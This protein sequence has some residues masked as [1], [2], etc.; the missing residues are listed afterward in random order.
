MLVVH[1]II[2]GIP[3]FI[4][5][6]LKSFLYAHLAK[7]SARRGGQLFANIFRLPFNLVLK[8]STEPTPN[9]AHGLRIA[10]SI[11]GVQ[12]PLLIDYASTDTCSYTLM[13]WIEGDCCS[14]VWDDLTP[15][16][17]QRIVRE[18]RMQI[19]VLRSRTVGRSRCICA[20][21]GA[22][23]SDPHIPWVR[24]DPQVFSSSSDFFKQVWVGLNFD[25]LRNTIKPAIQP[26]IDR[27]AV[28]IVF[29]HGDLLPKNLIL[30]GGLSQRRRSNTALTIIDWEYSGWMPLPWEALKATWLVCD[31]DEEE[32]YG[33]MREVFP[34][35]LADLEADWLWRTKANIPI[36][37]PA[38]ATRLVWGNVACIGD[39]YA[40]YDTTRV[41]RDLFNQSVFKRVHVQGSMRDTFAFRRTMKS[42]E[43][44]STVEELSF[45]YDEA[46]KSVDFEEELLE[47]HLKHAPRLKSLRINFSEDGN[48]RSYPNEFQ[49]ALLRTLATSAPG[50][51]RTLALIN[52][53]AH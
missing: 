16:D 44:I 25:R 27:D 31:R 13:S 14:D 9:E 18:L 12:A 35:S 33:M 30:P 34:E 48:A 49:Y 10:G 19:S 22:S 39:I 32:W 51:L 28:P 23:I 2:W 7:A 17:K 46:E 1:T 38:E 26:L 11:P 47:V 8:L 36:L 52:L 40:L 15:A 20:A 4:P 21:S 43:A 29:C 45:A 37:L 53:V 42:Q 5:S 3:R 41:L 24:E 50:T 6:Q